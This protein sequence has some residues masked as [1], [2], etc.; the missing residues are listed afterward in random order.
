MK[1]GPSRRT[2]LLA[3]AAAAVVTALVVALTAGVGSRHAHKRARATSVAVPS[4][5][6][7]VAG[8]LGISRGDLRRRLRGSTLA[9]IAR[10][11]PGR[12][13]AGVEGAVLA[14]HEQQWRS[15]G[16]SASERAARAKRLRARFGEDLVRPRHS[17]GDLA[18]AAAYLGISEAAVRAKLL[19]GRTLAQLAK[20]TPGRSRAGLTAAILAPRKQQLEEGMN[21]GRI[22]PEQ[23]KAAIA[24]LER[25][26][27]R[28][29]DRVFAKR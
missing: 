21:A 3:L 24:Q 22:T 26:V 12:S 16:L 2:L 25:R 15:A 14:A 1:H 8:Y 7:I 13:V 29:V 4:E 23:E 10:T 17:V 20:A 19:D 18:Y 11:T 6:S 9:E 5:L 28:E 27:P